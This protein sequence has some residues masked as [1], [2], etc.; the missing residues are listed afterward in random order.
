ANRMPTDEDSRYERVPIPEESA[1]DR[2]GSFVEIRHPYQPDEAVIEAQRCLQCAMPYCVQACPIAQDCREYILA[3]ATRDFDRAAV[4]TLTENSLATTLCKTCYHYCE[5]ACIM[6]ERG[7]AIAIRQLKRAAMELGKSD[8][9][10]VAS[11]PVHQRV[12]IVGAGP[13]GLHAAWELGLRGYSVTVFEKE[14]QIG[15]Q[16]GAIPKYHMDGWELEVD[17]ARFKRLDVTFRMGQKLGRDFTLD[18]LRSDGY[19]AIYLALGT[20]GHNSLGVPGEELPGVFP[21]IDLLEETNVGPPAALGHRVVVIGGGDVA[22]DA[23]RSA[24]RLT[25]GGD[26]VVVYRRK[27]EQMSAGA[28]EI[29]E[30]EEEGVRFLFERGPL[31]V[32]G[33]GKVEG[34]VVQ[35]MT[36]SPPGPSGRPAVVPVPG[37]EETLPCDSVIVAVGE[38]A[39]LSGLPKELDLA[40]GGQGWPM[41]KGDDTMTG[42]EG[43]FASGGKSVVH[44][45]A[46]GTKS[47]NGI[48]VYLQRQGGKPP[49]PR[50]DPFGRGTLPGLPKGYGGPTWKP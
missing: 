48:D 44:A 38:K 10:Y 21:A 34:V 27:R 24:L 2:V 20:P 25:G 41:G 40:F 15:G 36:L 23:V 16:V 26:V 32:V 22:M 47:A 46:A 33:S 50:P 28:E 5:D 18:S 6:H 37:T 8:L 1:R 45:M 31:R 29:S 19:R 4:V 11:A 35:Q 42:V 3:V 49:I 9:E 43:I 39:D 7:G 17:V 14:P 12:A 30:A 13:A